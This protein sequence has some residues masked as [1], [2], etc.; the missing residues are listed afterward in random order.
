M[1]NIQRAADIERLIQ[2]F[3]HD[4]RSPLGVAQGYASL[5][6]GQQLSDEDRS[7]ALRGVSDAL[8]RLSKLS[9]D[10][11]MLLTHYDADE[12][13][14]LVEASLLCERVVLEAERYGIQVV[15]GDACI[16]VKVGVGASL[17]WVSEAIAITLGLTKALPRPGQKAHTT[18]DVWRDDTVL[19]FS[20]RQGDAEPDQPADLVA[21]DPED[22]GTVA[23]MKAHHRIHRVQGR[24]WRRVGETRAS[25]VTLPLGQ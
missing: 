2:L 16:D 17:D 1:S 11:A 13:L 21:F 5:L 15:L 18:L 10:V 9:D 22:I 23:Q 7:R 14:G 3:M 19:W 6:G 25:A 8:T 24:V 4:L 12:P 20:A